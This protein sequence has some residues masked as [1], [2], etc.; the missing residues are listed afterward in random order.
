MQS[1]LAL[2]IEYLTGR[3]V[4]TRRET[5]RKPEWPPHPTRVF[6]ALVCAWGER[7]PLDAENDT[8]LVEQSEREREALMWLESLPAPELRVS[9]KSVRETVTV[10]VPANDSSTPGRWTKLPRAE[11]LPWQRPRQERFFP[12]VTPD[13]RFVYL[14]WPNISLAELNMHKP[15]LERLAN[16]V[17][18]VG[19]SS[20]LTRVALCNEAPMPT[21]R[22]ARSGESTEFALRVPSAGKLAYLQEAFA[23]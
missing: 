19:H 10:F 13:D 3:S 14:I 11:V 4:A 21:H 6:S 9:D 23:E 22:P 18:Y 20:S 16:N 8:S 12:S 2:Q 7:K 17:I 5:Y 1:M 15:A